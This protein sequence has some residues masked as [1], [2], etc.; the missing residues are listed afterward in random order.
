MISPIDLSRYI[1]LLAGF[2]FTSASFAASVYDSHIKDWSQAARSS[3]ADILAIG[4]SV[5]FF[6][7]DGWDAGLQYGASQTFGLAGSGV[8]S[9]ISVGQGEGLAYTDTYSQW[10]TS[11]TAAFGEASLANF[12]RLT[13]S[14]S[15]TATAGV[16]VYGSTL[17]AENDY[18]LDLWGVGGPGDGSYS[19][20]RR[21]GRS[22]WTVS[23]SQSGFTLAEDSQITHQSHELPGAGQSTT[24]V[25]LMANN[26][27]LT[28]IRVSEKNGT[29]VTVTS[30]GY[31]GRSTL[32]FYNDRWINRSESVRQQYLKQLVEGGS[33]KLLV[34]I[35]EGFNDRNETEP[36]VNGITD[37]D[38]TEAFIDN[39]SSLI[40]TIQNDWLGAGFNSEDL[41]F[42]TF[43]M[44]DIDGPSGELE[45]YSLG[46]K[47]LAEQTAGI[48]YL[49]ISTLGP[50]YTTGEG[51]GYYSDAIHLSR[52]GALYYGDQIMQSLFAVSD[53]RAG[54][55]NDDG[56]VDQSDY[57]QWAATYGYSVTTGTNTDLNEDGIIN[58]ADYTIWR[59]TAES[60]DFN[61]DSIVDVSDYNLWEATFGSNVTPGTGADSNRD[62]II[63][64]ADY[65]AWRDAVE[66]I[67]FNDDGLVDTSDYDL[68]A[69]TFGSPIIAGAGAD[70]NR[71]GIINAADYTV[72]RDTL[73]SA[74]LSL[75]TAIPEPGTPTMLITLML[76][77]ASRRTYR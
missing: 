41:S 60:A 1:V 52:N 48:S 4:D 33:G 44:Y 61:G 63:N 9:G 67:D 66:S 23:N 7:T 49:D 8:L 77:T 69:T 57:N 45:G 51:L 5:V 36:S 47:D 74:N 2:L 25:Q 72:W 30:L 65:T 50:D 12:G 39:V 27:S 43:G 38:S 62:G 13:T 46:L 40:S 58:A 55:F 22:P 26:L 59:D 73:P 14:S 56:V 16:I 3:R 71:D 21:L 75:S 53:P 42:L 6:G 20:R 37:G 11:S 32:D 24:H 15:N 18:I 68:W 64:A 28:G 17:P 70:G 34:P 54:D 19:I 35:F 76:M 29:G 31:G 10:T